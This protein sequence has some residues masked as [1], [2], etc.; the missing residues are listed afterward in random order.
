[1]P[2]LERVEGREGSE[3]A[4]EEEACR[5]CEDGGEDSRRGREA[6]R[7]SYPRQCSEL[8]RAIRIRVRGREGRVHPSARCLVDEV[9]ADLGDVPWTPSALLLRR[10]HRRKDGDVRLR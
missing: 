7:S 8:V 1:M 3:H 10:L 2:R 6:W 9:L 4:S 5:G